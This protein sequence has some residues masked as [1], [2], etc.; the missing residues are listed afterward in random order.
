MKWLLKK[1]I[2]E[3]EDEIDCV[4][5]HFA[6]EKIANK[7]AKMAKIQAKI[8]FGEVYTIEDFIE[9]VERGCIIP[10]DGTGYYWDEV[11]NEETDSVSF[12]INELRKASSTYK[13]VIWH[14]R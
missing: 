7:Y 3:I 2:Y 9:D 8:K 4:L 5:S 12:N 14:N 1:M 13:Y 11:K 6:E 10:Y